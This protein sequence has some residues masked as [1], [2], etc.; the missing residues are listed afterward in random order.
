MVSTYWKVKINKLKKFLSQNYSFVFRAFVYLTNLLYGVPL[1]QHVAIVSERGDI[2]GYLKVAIQQLP[3]SMSSSTHE[4]THE[5]IKL[6][7]TFKN[8]NGLTKIVFNDETY[9][10]VNITVVNLKYYERI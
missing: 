4:T 5:Q 7:K 1:T 3:T 8:A 6:M 10:Q 2:K 9:F